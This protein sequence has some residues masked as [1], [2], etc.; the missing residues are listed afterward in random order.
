MMAMPTTVAKWSG[1]RHRCEA[2][3]SLKHMVVKDVSRPSL[4]L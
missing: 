2:R 1:A 4:G 3:A